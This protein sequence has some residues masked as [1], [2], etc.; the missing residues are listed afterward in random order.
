MNTALSSQLSSLPDGTTAEDAMD[1]G[2][3]VLVDSVEQAAE[4]CNRLAP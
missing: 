2:F 4:A 3:A 1:N